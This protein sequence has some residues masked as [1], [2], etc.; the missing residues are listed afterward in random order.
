MT[1]HAEDGGIVGATH[2]RL[3]DPGATSSNSLEK[4]CFFA[5]LAQA[6]MAV[7]LAVVMDGSRALVRPAVDMGKRVQGDVWHI[8]KTFFGWMLMQRRLCVDAA[9]LLRRTRWS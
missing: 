1:A 6:R 9:S 2:K 8:Q 3:T 5:L 7:Y 4:L